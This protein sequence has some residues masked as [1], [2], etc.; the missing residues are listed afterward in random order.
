MQ[1]FVISALSLSPNR[2][3][4]KWPLYL[5]FKLR[6]RQ[7]H[8]GT[9][10]VYSVFKTTLNKS[11]DSLKQIYLQRTLPTSFLGK[12]LLSHSSLEDPT[13]MTWNQ[14][15]CPWNTSLKAVSSTAVIDWIKIQQHTE[16]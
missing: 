12:T 4:N 10:T 5:R 2:P 13:V 3:R 8:P 9:M 7:D 1:C 15:S 11:Y 14:S 6:L 16:E